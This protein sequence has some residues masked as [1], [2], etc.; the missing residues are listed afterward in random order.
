MKTDEVN[1]SRSRFDLE[2]KMSAEKPIF[3]YNNL[4]INYLPPEMNSSM[5]QDLFS[6]Y[7]TIVSCKVV[8]DH[9]TGI[10]KGYK[11]VKFNTEMEGR[12]AQKALHKHRIG[13]K[14]LKVSFSRKPQQ[15]EKTKN[16]TNLYVS[17]LDPKLDSE[18]L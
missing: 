4:I 11:F 8:V 7:G 14:T 16:N 3:D 15:G 2:S 1:L 17:N 13:K 12:A 5:L 18:D 6:N 10:S 9:P